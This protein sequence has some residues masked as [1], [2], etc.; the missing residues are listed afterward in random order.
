MTNTFQKFIDVIIIIFQATYLILKH[1]YELFL[2]STYQH[3]KQIKGNIVL[4]TG[5][6]GGLG[7]LL[8]LRLAKLEAIV[9]LWDVDEKGKS[10]KYSILK[11]F[12]YTRIYIKYYN[13]PNTFCGTSLEMT[14]TAI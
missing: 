11:L 4:V 7:R 8:C 1:I 3:R 14:I 12:I 5:G 13:I 6:G 9:V 2:P 10:R